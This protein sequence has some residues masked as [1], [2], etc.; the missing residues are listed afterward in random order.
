MHYETSKCNKK[1][2]FKLKCRQIKISHCIH[3][4]VLFTLLKHTLTTK[5][6]SCRIRCRFKLKPTIQN[7][8]P[9]IFA[10][11]G[12]RQRSKNYTAKLKRRRAE[13]TLIHQS[14]SISIPTN[15]S[16]N[17]SWINKQTQFFNN[18]FRSTLLLHAE[19]SYVTNQVKEVTTLNNE[20]KLYRITDECKWGHR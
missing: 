6:D 10:T 13:P 11:C 8:E 19:P 20:T 12:N 15:N 2:Y 18:L 16:G 9:N 4:M 3:L 17:G 14:P 5:S 1:G 7:T